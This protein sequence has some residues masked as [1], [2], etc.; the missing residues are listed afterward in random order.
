[1]Q[2]GSVGFGADLTLATHLRSPG[3]AVNLLFA[4]LLDQRCVQ[5]F[6]NR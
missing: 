1:M 5:G 3:G 6:S 2:V 4:A